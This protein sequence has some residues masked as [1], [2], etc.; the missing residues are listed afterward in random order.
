MP[1]FC[2][3]RVLSNLLPEHPIA[4]FRKKLTDHFQRMQ[5]WIG[6]LLTEV[7]KA[8]GFI[9]KLKRHLSVLNVFKGLITNGLFKVFKRFRSILKG[10][11]KFIDV[12]FL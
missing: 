9:E 10:V 6:S 4:L 7:G 3:C 8:V 12:L 1:V 5:Q 2:F 11:E